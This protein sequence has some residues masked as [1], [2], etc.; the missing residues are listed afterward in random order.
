MPDYKQ[1]NRPIRITTPLGPDAVL[2][3]GFTGQEAI[4]QLF[5]FQIDVLAENGKEVAF[6]KLLGKKLTVDL[7][8]PGPAG[9]RRYFNGICNR[10]S[11]GMR[12]NIFTTYRLEIVPQFWLLTKRAQSR[13]FQHISVPDILKKVLEGLDVNFELQGTF[14]Q[15]D[16]CVQYRETDFN[17]AS[18]LMEEEGIYYFFKHENGN[19]KIVLGNSPQSHQDMPVANSIVYEEVPSGKRDEDRILS[20]EKTQEM[21][22]SKS[23]LW[24][25]CFELPYK[26]LEADKPILES[27]AAG[28]I[29]HKQKGIANDKLEIYD[30]PGEYAQRFDGVNKGGGEQPAELQKIFEDNKRTVGIR[31]QQEAAPS[32]LALGTS[33]CRQFVSGYKFDLTRHFNGDDQYL[34]V[35]VQHR[36]HASMDYR[37]ESGE[38]YRYE[39]SFTC[40]PFAQPF[41]PARVT[42][43]P[44]VQ[45]TQ[46]AFV[47]G[48]AGEEIFT[49]KYGRVKVQ[50]HWDREGK[51]NADSSCWIRVTQ[52]IS[53]KRWGYS[54]VPRIG[55]EVIVA[56]LEGD[57][58]QPI[59]VGTVYNADQMPPYL[60]KGLDS[61]HPH[62]PK[63]SG[64]K[65]NTTPGGLGFNEWRFDDTKGKEQIF[66]H[67]QRN[68]DT[69]IRNDC[70][71][72]IR[73]D[74]HLI[75]GVKKD[76]DGNKIGDQREQVWQDK[77][78]NVKRHQEEHIEGSMKLMI[79]HGDAQDN[80]GNLDIVIEKDKKELIEANNH[81]H[82]KAAQKTKVD[83]TQDI[84]VDGDKKEKLGSNS[85]LH[86]TQDLKEKID[87]NLHQTIGQNHETKVGTKHAVD[88]GQEIHLKGG[89]KVI[90]EAGMQ[91]TIKGPGGFVDIGPTGVTIQG[92][93]VLINSGGSAGS[94][95]GSSPS[96]PQDAEKPD[97]AQKAKPTVPTEADD[98]VSGKKSVPDSWPGP[99]P[100]PTGI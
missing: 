27:V 62:D 39:N 10:V 32:V 60:G 5:S 48:P 36:A 23:L 55:Q 25:Y 99:A 18:R 96:A 100:G 73:H 68:M 45:G 76:K 40:M 44:F 70:M 46:T 83:G 34:L 29:T 90:I 12:S 87:G 51:N 65:S 79:G 98:S 58:D 3:V 97:D 88:S 4:S 42:P 30:Y 11:Q 1:A 20:W 64:F 69:K 37:S 67:G 7:L 57:P 14:Q 41:R 59:I 85:H 78:L 22:S 63:L 15:R 53:G 75:V 93:M 17:F 89:M 43:K 19:H 56:F 71:E 38:E 13:I 80:P 54:A 84:T 91:L 82:I 35:S 24:D 74:R 81:L 21:R 94:G 16:Y 50:F 49:D 77:H 66:I 95:S 47:V 86:V 33:T 72:R 2:P 8:L 6:D 61:E 92:T 26:H 28:K 9:T 52:P 31:M